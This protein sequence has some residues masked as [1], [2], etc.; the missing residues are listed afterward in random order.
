MD[1]YIPLCTNVEIHNL[2]QINYANDDLYLLD[3]IDAKYEKTD[4]GDIVNQQLQLTVIQG[5]RLQHILMQYDTLFDGTLG[6]YKK[7]QIHLEL[8]DNAKP[9]HY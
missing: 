9:V 7:T 1:K 5:E 4:I 8:E 6:H 2:T 3:I